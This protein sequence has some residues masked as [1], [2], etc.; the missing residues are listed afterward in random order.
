LP[1]S[2][3]LDIREPA[4]RA[5]AAIPGADEERNLLSRVSGERVDVEVIEWEWLTTTAASFGAWESEKTERLA[6][7]VLLAVVT[8]S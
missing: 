5:A 8:Q 6:V 7:V 4:L 3:L 1:R 2:Q